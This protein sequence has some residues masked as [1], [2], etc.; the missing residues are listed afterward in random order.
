MN[1]DFEGT[2]KNKNTAIKVVNAIYTFKTLLVIA[3]FFF[4]FLIGTVF[5]FSGMP[6]KRYSEEVNAVVVEN[7]KSESINRSKKIKKIILTHRYFLMSIMA[8]NIG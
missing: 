2:E 3:M 8:K 7:V 1:N 4:V 6:K 5:I